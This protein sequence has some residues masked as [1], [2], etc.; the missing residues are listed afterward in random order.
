MIFLIYFFLILEIGD[1][2]AK[3]KMV[4]NNIILQ[5]FLILV[6]EKNRLNYPSFQI[7]KFESWEQI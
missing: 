3:S 2:S 5:Q 4:K 1:V 7:W 6:L